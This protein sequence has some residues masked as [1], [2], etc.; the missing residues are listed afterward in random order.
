MV[1]NIFLHPVSSSGNCSSV[2]ELIDRQGDRPDPNG[3][4]L[5]GGMEG[6]KADST[7]TERGER[8]GKEGGVKQSRPCRSR[9][10][11]RGAL[12]P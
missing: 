11:G 7:M 3:L 12:T 9:M 4:G 1:S 2:G 6:R 5:T 8:E 10:G